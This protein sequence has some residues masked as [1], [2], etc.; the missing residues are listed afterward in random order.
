[1]PHTGS[2]GLLATSAASAALLAGGTVLYRRGR[3]A[4]RR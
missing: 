4:S 2:E 1:M 3:A